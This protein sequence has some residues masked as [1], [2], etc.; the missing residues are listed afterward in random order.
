M[1]CVNA[2]I[3]EGVHSLQKHT[4]QGQILKYLKNLCQIIGWQNTVTEV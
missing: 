1:D 3:F 2:I 4:D